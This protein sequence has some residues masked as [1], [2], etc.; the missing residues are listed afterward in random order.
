MHAFIQQLF[1][2]HSWVPGTEQEYASSVGV[3]IL[4]SLP[5]TIPSVPKTPPAP[6]RAQKHAGQIGH[7]VIGH[8]VIGSGK[9]IVFPPELIQFSCIVKSCDIWKERSDFMLVVYGVLKYSGLSTPLTQLRN[10]TGSEEVHLKGLFG[11]KQ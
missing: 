9:H 8:T 2:E 3:G 10:E 1:V 7:T 4:V 11:L 6:E 5:T